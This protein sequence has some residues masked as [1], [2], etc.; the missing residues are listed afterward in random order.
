[1][2]VLGSHG[3]VDGTALS[4]HESMNE[5]RYYSVVANAGVELA[6]LNGMR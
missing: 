1:M 6:N 2:A 5:R 3:F 4:S